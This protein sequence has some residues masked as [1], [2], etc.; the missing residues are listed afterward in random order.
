MSNL[1]CKNTMRS[2]SIT[3]DGTVLQ[4]KA[5]IAQYYIKK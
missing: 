5:V 2:S 4:G 3:K 1:K